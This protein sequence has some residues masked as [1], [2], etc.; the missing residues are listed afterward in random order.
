[1]RV[2]YKNSGYKFKFGRD[3]KDWSIEKLHNLYLDA[4]NRSMLK[5]KVILSII[6]RIENELP[7]AGVYSNMK[8]RVLF[9][10]KDDKLFKRVLSYNN[11]YESWGIGSWEELK[12]K[13]SVLENREEKLNLLL[14]CQKQF[15]LGDIYDK[16]DRDNLYLWRIPWEALCEKVND[17]LRKKF[18][19]KTAPEHFTITI[20]DKNYVVHCDDQSRYNKFYKTF[21]LKNENIHVDL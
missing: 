15:E 20:G 3:P 18:D 4:R 7:D 16:Y 8:T 13:G 2:N 17:K 6:D 5:R 21:S 10:E 11:G 9:K 14:S 1:M 19:N 12:F